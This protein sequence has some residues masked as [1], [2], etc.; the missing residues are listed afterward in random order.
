MRHVPAFFIIKYN[1]FLVNH[2]SQIWNNLWT[3][4]G[5]SS[6]HIITSFELVPVKVRMTKRMCI[7]SPTQCLPSVTGV[8]CTD[9]TC[10]RDP[11]EAQTLLLFWKYWK[12]QQQSLNVN[13]INCTPVNCTPGNV[14][15][16]LPPKITINIIMTMA[17]FLKTKINSW[18]SITS[19]K[20][21]SF[22]AARLFLMRVIRSSTLVLKKIIWIFSCVCFNVSLN[23]RGVVSDYWLACRSMLCLLSIF[24]K[25]SYQEVT[26]RTSCSKN[27]RRNLKPKRR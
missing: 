24:L 1:C 23:L 21:S 17:Y 8:R 10:Q 19:F 6:R 7:F 11:L 5:G 18:N 12:T 9:V 22:L 16:F 20:I 25:K 15:T 13:T 14:I 27:P 4:S 26:E 3:T 2:F